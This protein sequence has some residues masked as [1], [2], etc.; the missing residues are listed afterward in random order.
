[1]ND[2]K[3][4]KANGV[5]FGTAKALSQSAG[6]ILNNVLT[7]GIFAYTLNAFQTTN[8]IT[9]AAIWINNDR[10]ITPSYSIQEATFNLGR[11]PITGS[12]LQNLARVNNKDHYL[13][14]DK[15]GGN[16][17][18][19]KYAD[20][21]LLQ[22]FEAAGL[23]P[24]NSPIRDKLKNIQDLVFIYDQDAFALGLNSRATN[25]VSS[26]YKSS[27]GVNLWS[28]LSNFNDYSLTYTYEHPNG[29][30]TSKKSALYL[31]INNVNIGG[32]LAKADNNFNTP[33]TGLISFGR[34]GRDLLKTASLFA[35]FPSIGSFIGGGIGAGGSSI[36]GLV[37]G[38]GPGK[39]IALG[40]LYDVATG[41]YGK[42]VD[43]AEI[44]KQKSIYCDSIFGQK[45]K[46]NINSMKA[47][48][49]VTS[50]SSAILGLAKV[51]P[52]VAVSFAVDILNMYLTYAE[53]EMEQKIA[54]GL[55]QCVDTSFKGIA[56]KEF[57]PQKEVQDSFQKVFEPIKA[58]AFNV[59]GSLAPEVSG[60]INNVA[61]SLSQQVLNI[62]GDISNNLVSA[63]GKEVYYVNLKDADIKWFQSP[64]CS[65]DIC[66]YDNTKQ[67]YVCNT[68]KGYFL[69]DQD[70]KPILNGIPQALS[71]TFDIPNGDYAF[72][73]NVVEIKK[74]ETNSDF[75]Q[76]KPTGVSL[77]AGQTCGAS[78]ILG[79]LGITSTDQSAQNLG[80]KEA[81]GNLQGV[82][83]KDAQIWFDK[84]D[85]VVQ[86][87]NAKTC[88]DG[89]AHGE[90]EVAR[91]SGGY[92]N[93]KRDSNGKVEV[94]NADNSVA[95]SFN[96]GTDGAIS[97]DNALLR[98]GQP[99]G[100]NSTDYS[101]LY[102][103]FIYNL[104]KFDKGDLTSFGF[105]GICTDNTGANAGVNLDVSLSTE[106]NSQAKQALKNI[107]FT[108]FQGPNN[109]TIQFKDGNACI[110]D[111]SGTEAC[112]QIDHYN[113]STGRLV[114]T[115]GFELAPAIGP[116]GVPQFQQYKN[117]RASGSPI[118][119]YLGNGLG[120]SFQYNPGTGQ[121]SI[122]NQFQ[123]PI[124]PN[125]GFYG[126]G[127]TAFMTPQ[128]QPWGQKPQPGAGGAGVPTP[129][130]NL[131]AQLP[132]TPSGGELIIFLI[133]L[134]GSLLLVR[135]RYRRQ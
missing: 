4:N 51:T 93:F 85:A 27:T 115:D 65:I 38:A 77:A 7:R 125:F 73:Q 102:H 119:L 46:D 97:F 133:A 126:A 57:V 95:C 49:G 60:Q 84:N 55:S 123:M 45:E 41:G 87:T 2:I 74:R 50:A 79:L 80:V 89:T 40:P 33:L 34:F 82:Y 86:F 20:S 52:L 1:L 32:I 129:Q 72:V 76:I 118:P 104:L 108:N 30:L 122:N 8:F 21:V 127:G 26:P 62:N 5:K 135:I 47:A 35:I 121:I 22:I 67:G 66:Q 109:E 75:L 13:E 130:P 6:A 100:A 96:L 113:P 105:G 61:K 98:S 58:D 12:D 90:R 70:G 53:S 18:L 106:K 107:C 116:D 31:D 88:E 28:F 17:N 9:A 63:N 111:A 132:W 124:N 112:H 78:N 128:P 81:F 15:T 29:F 117:G 134:L 101:S 25:V 39:D 48:I 71:A 11:D 94:K 14:I 24:K 114:F 120:G 19:Q 83:T 69:Y 42:L 37:I 131:L 36:I 99:S 16:T 44:Y 43:I 10:V 59:L 91:Y 3:S 56:Y 54:E 103:L 110:K 64:T 68:Q 23:S 92:L